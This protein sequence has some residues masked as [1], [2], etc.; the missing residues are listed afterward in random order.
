MA[1]D[2]ASVEEPEPFGA[3]VFVDAS[4]RRA[5]RVERFA[6]LVV[7]AAMGYGLA[8]LIA[9]LT[10]VP[11]DGAIVPYPDLGSTTPSHHPAGGPASVPT[12]VS[13]GSPGTTVPT[14]SATPS[15]TATKHA[16]PSAKPTANPTHPS[17]R[18]T[19]T[20]TPA[21]GKSTSAPGVTRRPTAKPT[22]AN[23]GH[24]RVQPP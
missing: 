13:T 1:A 11:I 3:P 5:R 4:G 24:G 20:A 19:A 9:A 22:V 8:L 2:D 6:A 18:P 7:L 14:A 12:G 16:T 10:G 15:A 23:T 17:G 21:H